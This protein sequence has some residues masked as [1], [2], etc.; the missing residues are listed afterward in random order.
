MKLTVSEAAPGGRAAAQAE[1]PDFQSLSPLAA[2]SLILGLSSAAALSSPLLLV[3]PA[4]AAGLAVL[5]LAKIGASDGALTG[6]R[7]AR[8]GLAIALACAA[9]TLVRDPVRNRLM[10]RQA[11]DAARR[12]F[13]LIAEGRLGESRALLAPQA[14]ASLGPAKGEPGSPP[15]APEAVESVTLENLRRDKLVQ[16]LSGWK[17]PLTA[18]IE[19]GT[20]QSPVFD[21]PRTMSAATFRVA[22]ADGEDS[23]RVQMNFARAPYFENEGEPWRIERWTVLEGADDGGPGGSTASNPA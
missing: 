15:P 22:P 20:A 17:T 6:A 2:L 23:C 11:A 12:W 5:A 4:A 10:Q 16:K 1:A 21:G 13:T 7:L 14:L 8:W 3:I 9:A 19:A 18:T